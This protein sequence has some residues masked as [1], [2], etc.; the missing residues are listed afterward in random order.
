M[1]NKFKDRRQAGALLARELSKYRGEEDVV[2]LALPRGGVPVAFEVAR[3]LEAPLDVFLVRKLGVPGQEELAMGAIADGGIRVINKEVLPYLKITDEAIEQVAKKEEAELK[4]RRREYT[5]DR[6][7]IDITGKVAIIIDDGLATGSTM[8]AAI[9]AV[10]EK[11]PSKIIV[12]VPVAPPSTCDELEDSVDDMICLLKPEYFRAV[13]LWYDVFDQTSDQ[14][15]KDLLQK[16]ESER[17]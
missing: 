9:A 13:G 15:V 7:P 4:R 10:K 14:E 17:E 3:E 11:S 2:I 12:G 6:E 1:I 8:K 16:A 5:G